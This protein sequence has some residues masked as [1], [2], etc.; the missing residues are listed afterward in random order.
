[1]FILLKLSLAHL[2]SDFLLQFEELFLLKLK[3][4]RGHFLHALCHV[5]VSLVILLP[6]LNDPFIWVFVFAISSIHFFQDIVKYRLMK[7]KKYFFLLFVGD[8]IL[9]FMF[10]STILFFPVSHK[11]LGFPA[12]PM[13]N[14]LYTENEWT[15]YSIAFLITTVTGNFLFNALST[16]CFDKTREDRFITTPEIVHG[17][18]ERT[19]I[20]GLF[21]LSNNLVILL[22]S[23]LV[24]I[25]RL[26]SA[27]IRDKTDF[28][29]SFIYGALIG[30]LFR[31]WI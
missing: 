20:T 22:I 24:G 12:F 26:F 16:S 4:I 13:F 15:L 27:R 6:Y 25:F 7:Y 29:I 14:L 10:L 3:S 23:P 8:Q 30:L 21:L 1:M 31:L 5:L 19:V 9:H 2:I 11:I 28:L 17:I 18:L